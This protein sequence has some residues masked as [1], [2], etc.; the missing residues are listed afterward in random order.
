[1]TSLLIFPPQTLMCT[2]ICKHPDTHSPDLDTF[3]LTHRH[4]SQT[5]LHVHHT[6]TLS[7][8][9]REPA[10]R[11][12]RE[13]TRVHAQAQAHTHTC[14]VPVEQKPR[15]DAHIHTKHIQTHTNAQYQWSGSRETGRRDLSSDRC[16]GVCSALDSSSLYSTPAHMHRF[17][18]HL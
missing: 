11:E 17:T 3:T 4:Y 6:Q 9:H 13:D 12:S 8:T 14:P 7:L 16:L 15:E 2:C 5:F 1:M 10:E 18:Q